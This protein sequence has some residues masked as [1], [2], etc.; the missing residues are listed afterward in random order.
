M[1]IYGLTNA[2]NSVGRSVAD[3]NMTSKPETV[4]LTKKGEGEVVAISEMGKAAHQLDVGRFMVK[5]QEKTSE[6]IKDVK[7]G[8][9]SIIDEQI[10]HIKLRI[11]A[12]KQ[13]LKALSGDKSE[14][15]EKKREMLNAEIMQLSG[16][17]MVLYNEKSKNEGSE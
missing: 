2:I 15:A 14:S 7:I 6:G 5:R 8:P 11:E 16:M 12:L 4:M 1:N 13:A 3:V 10:E 17:L 9:T